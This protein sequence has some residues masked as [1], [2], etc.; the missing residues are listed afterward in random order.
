MPSQLFVSE[1]RKVLLSLTVN[2]IGRFVFK[3]EL[4]IRTNLVLYL[5]KVQNYSF[6]LYSNLNFNPNFALVII[7]QILE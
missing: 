5:D 4:Y 1:L 6:S 3:L 7:Q 2:K